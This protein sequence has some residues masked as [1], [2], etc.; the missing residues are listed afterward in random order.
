[1]WCGVVFSSSPPLQCHLDPRVVLTISALFSPHLGFQHRE[2]LSASAHFFLISTRIFRISS[3]LLFFSAF[4]APPQSFYSHLD[5]LLTSPK[6]FLVSSPL[7]SSTPAKVTVFCFSEQFCCCLAYRSG[8][9]S[10]CLSA[11][12][13]WL[14]SVSVGVAYVT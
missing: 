9:Q 13:V 2:L 14:R 11:S 3:H 7:I 4:S 8:S 6:P 5:L 10:V 1:M 12:K